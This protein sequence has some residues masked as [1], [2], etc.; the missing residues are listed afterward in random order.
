MKKNLDLVFIALFI[1]FSVIGYLNE[2]Q[3]LYYLAT[4]TA[5]I[6]FII[7]QQPPSKNGPDERDQLINLKASSFS[8]ITLLVMT[9]LGS[10]LLDIFASLDQFSASEVIQMVIT[11]LYLSYTIAYA[12]LKRNL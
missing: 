7:V 6:G 10:V 5:I 4:A 8:F 12:Y 11:L 3:I 2:S 9:S 1:L